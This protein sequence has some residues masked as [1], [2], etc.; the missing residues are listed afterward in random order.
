MSIAAYLNGTY[1]WLLQRGGY[2]GIH[3]F[4]FGSEVF[5]EIRGQDVPR[6]GFRRLILRDD[7]INLLTLG[8]RADYIL[9][10]L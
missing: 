1:Y 3:S 8:E 10:G 4:D 9:Y 6:N 2:C 7:S 5:G